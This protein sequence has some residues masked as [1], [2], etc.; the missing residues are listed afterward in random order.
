M[1]LPW[2]KRYDSSSCRVSKL[3]YPPY[4]DDP[5][6][7]HEMQHM[8]SWF[9]HACPCARA[10]ASHHEQML[11]QSVLLEGHTMLSDQLALLNTFTFPWSITKAVRLGDADRGTAGVGH[12]APQL[13]TYASPAQSICCRWSLDS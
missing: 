2:T 6:A 4:V 12:C 7:H 8:H 13:A 5:A 9:A 3:L 10:D 11:Q 1:S